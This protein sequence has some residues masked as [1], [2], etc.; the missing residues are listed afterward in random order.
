MISRSGI[1]I[2]IFGNKQ[3]PD[4]GRVVAAD[5]MLYEFEIAK[6]HDN[7]IVP[8]GCTG[9]VAERIWRIIKNNPDKYYL[10]LNA[11]KRDLFDKLMIK[12][13]GN[14]LINTIAEFIKAI[15]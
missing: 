11:D 14:S 9:F 4:T 7:I 2:F 8:I 13:D 3:D 1:S 12:M 15:R 10:N 6:Q 5:G